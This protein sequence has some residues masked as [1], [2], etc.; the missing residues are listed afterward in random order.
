V[1]E[2]AFLIAREALSN[3]FKHAQAEKIEVELSYERS[4]L[5]VQVRD[6]GSGIDTAT[7]QAGGRADH[8]GL[9]GM[10]ERAQKIGGSLQIYSRHHAGTEIELR[11][12][13]SV[14]YSDRRSRR[15]RPLR[16]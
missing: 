9:L 10:R 8:W 2:E 7:L 16:L 3:A 6:D 4:A 1:R 11:V 14:A 15:R 12:P 13:A 5:R